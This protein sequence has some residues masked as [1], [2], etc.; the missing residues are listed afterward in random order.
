M[1]DVVMTDLTKEETTNKEIKDNS[2]YTEFRKTLGGLE[3][4]ITLKDSKSLN[5]Y[6]KLLNKFRRGFSDEDC[7]FLCDNFLRSKFHFSFVP[8]LDATLKVNT[9]KHK[10][11]FCS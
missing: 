4:A 6:A 5:Q 1:E 2:L 8:T 10:K 9:N 3:K 7:Q 11:Y